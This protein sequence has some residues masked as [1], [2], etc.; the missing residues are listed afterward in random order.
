MTNFNYDYTP[1]ADTIEMEAEQ[2]LNNIVNYTPHAL[3]FFGPGAVE[4]RPEMR[5]WVALEGMQPSF[6]IPS[7]GMLSAKI[8]TAPSEQLGGIR[9]F[10]KQVTGC[11]PLPE[12]GNVV[13]V[14]ALYAMAAGKMQMDMSRVFTVADPVFSQ[15]GRTVLG[16]LGICPAF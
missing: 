6:S 9:V 4:F 1:G 15:D 7:S 3:N 2:R 5:K 12:K 11:D 10:S 8:E 16:C 13:I 14:S